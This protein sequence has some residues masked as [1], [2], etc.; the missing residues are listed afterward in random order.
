M[1]TNTTAVPGAKVYTVG[2]QVSQADVAAAIAPLGNSGIPLLV[3]GV[4]FIGNVINGASTN[5]SQLQTIQTAYIDPAA[6]NNPVAPSFGAGPPTVLSA[7]GTHALYATS[8]WYTSSTGTLMGVNDSTGNAGVVSTTPAADGSGVYTIGPTNNVGP[9]GVVWDPLIYNP[10]APAMS[11][12]AALLG[13]YGNSVSYIDKPPVSNLFSTGVL[14]VPLAQVVTNGDL[15][16]DFSTTGLEGNNFIALDQLTFNF[17][18]GNFTVDPHAVLDYSTN[19]IHSELT[20]GGGLASVGGVQVSP[21]MITADGNLTSTFA[22]T[23][24]ANLGQTIGAAAAQQINFALAGSTAQAW[25]IHF[26]GT[27]QGLSTVVFHYDPTL[28]GS[29]PEMDL[30]IEHYENGAWVV[31]TGQVV[32]TLAHTIT[33]QTDSFSPFVLAQTPEPSAFVLLSVGA[34][35]LLGWRRRSAKRTRSV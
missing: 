17:L 2:V 34:L 6:E 22:T 10:A 35:A 32:D 9:A 8:W 3:Q 19:T 28:I 25:D 27:L 29:I 26:T 31:P 24:A 7:A 15:H 20:A 12:E 33:F 21:T 23:T 1:G 30:R 16:F 18:G 14:T 11:M 5:P 4:D 13:G